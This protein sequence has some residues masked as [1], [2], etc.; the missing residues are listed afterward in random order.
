MTFML[1]TVTVASRSG[2]HGVLKN[3]F[4]C[5]VMM[6]LGQNVTLGRG[7]TI[8]DGAVVAG[9]SVVAKD[10]PPYAI[11]GGNPAS[12]IKYR[13]SHELIHRLLAVQWWKYHPKDFAH[14]DLKDPEKMVKFFEDHAADLEV[15]KPSVLTADE[16]V[17][18]AGVDSAAS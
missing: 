16:I 9:F 7:V 3:R 13:F 5:W 2:S 14:E 8:G 4:Q 11:V 12:V 10:V 18:A 1:I 6:W 17:E 15:F